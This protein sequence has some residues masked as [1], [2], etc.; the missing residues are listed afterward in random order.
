MVRFQKTSGAKQVLIIGTRGSK[1]ALA[2]AEIARERLS[3]TVPD[4]AVECKIIA[5]SGDRDQR[6]TLSDIGGKGF[7]IRELEQ[8]LLDKTID[9]A[10]HSFKDVTA[11]LAD[12]LRLSAFFRPESICDALAL[13]KGLILQT[14][15]RG[16]RIG[17]GS[18]RRKVLLGRI[19]PDLVITDIR[20]N[21]DTRLRKLDEGQYEGIMLSEAGLIRL[22]LDDRISHRFDPK[23]FYPA[24]GQGVITLETRADDDV[25]HALCMQTGDEDQRYK[26]EAEFALLHAV[27]F[28]CRAPLGVHTVLNGGTLMMKGFIVKSVGGEFIEKAESGPSPD[29]ATVGMRLGKRFLEA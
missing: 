8:A 10:V 26:S 27:G 5:T 1:L 9:I 22:K 13:K 3:R 7:F 12:G 11:N 24:P 16:G 6:S 23:T 18:L 15:P 19:R 28:D 29:S 2:Q 14:L 17:T 20:G 21:I 4:L 25:S